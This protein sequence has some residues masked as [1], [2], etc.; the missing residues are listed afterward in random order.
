VPP[1]DSLRSDLAFVGNRL[2]DRERR[3][4]QLFLRAAELAPE[5]T[6]ILGGEGWAEKPLPPN[7]RWIGHVSTGDH[8][9]VNCSPRMVLNIN[10][11]SMANVG[12]S[13]PTRVFEA[14]GSGACMITDRWPGIDLFF[15]EGSEILVA[16]TAEEI[17]AYLRTIDDAQARQ[18][19]GKM[20]ERALRDHTYAQRAAEVDRILRESRSPRSASDRRRASNNTAQTRTEVVA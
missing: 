2:P 11:D 16:S 4:E 20:R 17:V 15:G 14:A 12:F 1:K 10:R 8:N 18:I 19:G 13:P 6:F 9:A 7:V 3:V 5:M